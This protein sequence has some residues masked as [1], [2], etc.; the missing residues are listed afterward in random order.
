MERPTLH[1][2]SMERALLRVS[3]HVF[4]VVF[5]LEMMIKGLWIYNGYL[6]NSVFLINKILTFCKKLK[7]QTQESM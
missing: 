5:L 4:T 3:N 2:D 6:G 1:E 7:D